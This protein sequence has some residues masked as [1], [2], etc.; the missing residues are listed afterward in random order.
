MAFSE[1]VSFTLSC[2]IGSLI[3]LFVIFLFLGALIVPMFSAQF[4]SSFVESLS[5]DISN[6]RVS[7]GS[8]ELAGSFEIDFDGE[9]LFCRIENLK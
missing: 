1:F 6:A 5:E 2:F 7:C 4:E 8:E 3:A 9:K